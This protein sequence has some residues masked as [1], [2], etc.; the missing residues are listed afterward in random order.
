MD[1]DDDNPDETRRLHIAGKEPMSS[2][3]E[4]GDPPG[5]ALGLG[6]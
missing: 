5:P 4:R 3:R 6:I 2:K 1:S